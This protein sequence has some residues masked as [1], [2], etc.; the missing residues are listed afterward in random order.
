MDK[1][2]RQKYPVSVFSLIFND[3]GKFLFASKD[4]NSHWTAIGGWM[5]M[6]SVVECIE[7]EIKE[8][9]GEID[10]QILDIV[11][12][13]VWNYKDKMPIISIFALVKYIDGELSADDDIKE[14]TLKWFTPEELNNID[15]Y[16]PRQPEIIQKALFFMNEYVK[17]PEVDFLKYKWRYLS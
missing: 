11:D 5:E 14:F 17:K 15:V 12:T 8:E 7:R 1:K 4:G 10:F 2:E 3:E 6:E 9:L 16:C 13:H